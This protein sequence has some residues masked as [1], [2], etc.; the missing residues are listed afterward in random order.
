M[1]KNEFY[2][3]STRF[4]ENF[5]NY[6]FQTDNINEKYF[7]GLKWLIAIQDRS[8]QNDKLRNKFSFYIQHGSTI[9]LRKL[10]SEY[11]NEDDLIHFNAMCLIDDSQTKFKQ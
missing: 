9:N 3:L 1:S 5:K 11:C 2:I 7:T 8:I 10:L 6:C 4:I